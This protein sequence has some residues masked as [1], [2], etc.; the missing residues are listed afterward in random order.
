MQLDGA[1]VLVVEDEPLVAMFLED[2]LEELGCTVAATAWRLAQALEMAETVEADAA[3]LDVNIAGERVF[4][5]AEA[6]SRRGVPYIFATGY[7]SAGLPP[8]LGRVPV[9]AKPIDQNSLA[10]ALARV[11]KERA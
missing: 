10:E 2:L 11:L 1:R 6:L 8:E 4:P 3:V 5:V 7:G 9:L